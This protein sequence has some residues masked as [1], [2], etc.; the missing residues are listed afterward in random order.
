M[1]PGHVVR[2]DEQRHAGRLGGADRPGEVGPARLDD[3]RAVRRVPR[4]PDRPE[5][6]VPPRRAPDEQQETARLV[7]HRLVGVVDHLLSG[8]DVL[9][10]RRTRDLEDER[11]ECLAQPAQRRTVRLVMVP[12]RVLPCLDVR[13]GRA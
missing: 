3:N 10:V 12:R 8:E 9:A 5:R 4:V 7:G 11:T 13:Q 1:A 2:G 6:L